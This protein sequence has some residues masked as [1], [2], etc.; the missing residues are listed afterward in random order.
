MSEFW[1]NV[2]GKY[3]F[4]LYGEMFIGESSDSSF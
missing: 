4:F 3:I 2:V 1:Y